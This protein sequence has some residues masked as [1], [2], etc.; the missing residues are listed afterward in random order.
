MVFAE[1][2][3]NVDTHKIKTTMTATKQ[4]QNKEKT[5]NRI[6]LSPVQRDIFVLEFNQKKKKK[7]T[8]I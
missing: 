6:C 3:K 5:N 4:I 7:Q 2:L 1:V 8:N